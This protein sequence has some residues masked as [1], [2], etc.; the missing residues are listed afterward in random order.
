[1]VNKWDQLWPK[2]DDMRN[3]GSVIV[4]NYHLIAIIERMYCM[5]EPNLNMFHKGRENIGRV[6]QALILNSNISRPV[7]DAINR[8]VKIVTNF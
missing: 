6:K 7:R 1:M 8:G 2:L 3:K 4:S 5:Q